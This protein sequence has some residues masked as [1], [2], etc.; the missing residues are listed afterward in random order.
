MDQEEQNVVRYV[1]KRNNRIL[2]VGNY[3]RMGTMRIKTDDNR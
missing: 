1:H 3:G 2:D